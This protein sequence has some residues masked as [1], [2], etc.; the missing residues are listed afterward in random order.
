MAATRLAIRL[1]VK[2]V[3]YMKVER[4]LIVKKI[5]FGFV[6]VDAIFE[7]L[8]F[9]GQFWTLHIWYILGKLL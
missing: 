8:S 5:V 6:G 9:E 2:T 1:I 4:K 7:S 3:E